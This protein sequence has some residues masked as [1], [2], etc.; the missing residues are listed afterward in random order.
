MLQMVLV[1]ASYSAT[2]CMASSMAWA[3]CFFD[4]LMN[5]CDWENTDFGKGGSASISHKMFVCGL[6]G[7]DTSLNIPDTFQV[8]ESEI[9]F[10]G[11]SK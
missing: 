10:H 1:A 11:F 4:K 8:N 9:A 6:P 3:V 7:G 5:I 2:S